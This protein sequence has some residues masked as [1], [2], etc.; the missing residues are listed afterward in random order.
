MI[1]QGIEKCAVIEKFR[2]DVGDV[3]P[4]AG[5][6]CLSRRLEVADKWQEGP[7]L[8]DGPL[9]DRVNDE[10]SFWNFNILLEV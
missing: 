2:G 7:H 5:C 8:F 6:M 4:S 1:V 3:G 10:V 9:N